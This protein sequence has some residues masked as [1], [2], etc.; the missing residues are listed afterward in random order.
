MA[1]HVFFSCF[2]H[3]LQVF[4]LFRTY[5][6][7]V[8]SRFAKVV[9]PACMCMGVE[10]AQAIG[11]GNRVSTYRNRAMWDTEPAWDTEQ[12]ET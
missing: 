3:M 5:I 6:A 9:Q 10:G 7:N 11:A 2:R 1:T 4:Q 8:S 12:H